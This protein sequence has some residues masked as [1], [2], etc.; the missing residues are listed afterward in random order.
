MSS[1][2]STGERR[3]SRALLVALVLTSATLMTLD[4]GHDGSA[5]EPLRGAVGTVL[6]PAE[7]AAATAARPFQA[8]PAWFRTR[9]DLRQDV[10]QLEAENADLRRQVETTGLDRNRL[11]EFDGLTAAARTQ[12]RAVV[13]ARVVA[14]GPA[15]SF[16]R[17]V[18]ID[19]GSDAGI[20]ADQTVIN[21]DGLVGRVL[22]VSRS[23]ATVLL[24]LD[25]RSVVGGRI[26]ASME[27]GFLSG[28]G[29]LGEDGRLDLELVDDAVTPARGDVVVTWGSHGGAPYVSGVPIGRV[30][31][32][33]ASLRDSSRRAVVEPYVDFTALDVVG[34]VVPSGTTSDRAVIEADGS[35]R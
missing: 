2:G 3:P 1:G 4:R 8:V 7:A 31:Q 22:R 26:G 6:G 25:S 20:R 29:V 15:Q 14:L 9:G 33:F 12:G 5:V 13:P 32:V 30:T 18:T 27:V 17:T 35:L 23:T 11:A 10:A 24:V 28:R 16:T 34:V 19:A 21:A